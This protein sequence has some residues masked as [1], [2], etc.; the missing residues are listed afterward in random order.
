MTKGD[1]TKQA[2]SNGAVI[3]YCQNKRERN[4]HTF[5][6]DENGNG[7][8]LM[9]DDKVS[10]QDFNNSFPIGLIKHTR[11]EHIDGRQRLMF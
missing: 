11:H 5:R 7:Y 4:N 9:G 10:E 8:Y 3:Q 6:I 2:S 1:R